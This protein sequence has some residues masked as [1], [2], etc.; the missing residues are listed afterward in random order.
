MK[1]CNGISYAEAKLN[2]CNP[3]IQS[4]T[5]IAI[6]EYKSEDMI[7]ITAIMK[8]ALPHHASY[9]LRLP[10]QQHAP[11]IQRG[12]QILHDSS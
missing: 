10:L 11:K 2:T 9:R 4:P 5:V 7:N 1:V 6:I 8:F 12:G 3:I